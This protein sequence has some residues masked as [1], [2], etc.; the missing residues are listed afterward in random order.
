MHDVPGS[1]LATPWARTQAPQSGACPALR[2]LRRATPSTPLGTP[3]VKTQARQ[4][5]Q[6]RAQGRAQQQEAEEHG[7]V[8]EHEE[9]GN[10]VD[11]DC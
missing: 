6:Q 3:W 7:E 5:A 9:L 2:R 11:V 8:A 1:P 10:D 4:R